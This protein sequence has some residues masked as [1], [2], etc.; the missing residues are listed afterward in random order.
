MLTPDQEKS[1]ASALGH[2]DILQPGQVARVAFLSFL[3]VGTPW[4][5][6]KKTKTGA[7][8]E[9][10]KTILTSGWVLDLHRHIVTNLHSTIRNTLDRS[11]DN[12]KQAKKRMISDWEREAL[13]KAPIERRDQRRKLADIMEKYCWLMEDQ[14]S[15]IGRRLFFL[16]TLH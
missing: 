15:L 9:V 8:Y 7:G 4:D 2:R 14:V 6:G 13:L 5:V 16:L 1:H 11:K 12:K 3:A 10:I